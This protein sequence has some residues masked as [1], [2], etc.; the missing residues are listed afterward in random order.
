MSKSLF[1][2]TP[3]HAMTL[4]KYRKIYLKIHVVAGFLLNNNLQYLHRAYT[5]TE[6]HGS[7]QKYSTKL[8]FI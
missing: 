8:I 2:A 5:H 4:N 3:K 6:D 1:E 7:L